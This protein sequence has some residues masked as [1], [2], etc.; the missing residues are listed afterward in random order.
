MVLLIYELYVT[1]CNFFLAGHTLQTVSTQHQQ[2]VLLLWVPREEDR[3]YQAQKSQIWQN[4]LLWAS[5]H[6]PKIF[7]RYVGRDCQ[8]Y[9]K[10][11]MES[12]ALL[13]ILGCVHGTLKNAACPPNLVIPSA[14]K[15]ITLLVPTGQKWLSRDGASVK[16]PNLMVEI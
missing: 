13:V 4:C 15:I 1:C 12:A 14:R 7:K 16:G 10:L 5:V 2:G 8:N 9:F 3:P 11:Q 6:S